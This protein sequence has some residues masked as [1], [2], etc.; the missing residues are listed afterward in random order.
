M[1]GF[2]V[3]ICLSR[4]RREGEE[5]EE[6]GEFYSLVLRFSLSLAVKREGAIKLHA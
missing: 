5:K 1:G 3:P 4:S 2:I 6:K